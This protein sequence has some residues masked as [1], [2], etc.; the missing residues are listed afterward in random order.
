MRRLLLQVR[1]YRAV[2]SSPATCQARGAE[3]R[4]D[5]QEFSVQPHSSRCVVCVGPRRGRGLQGGLWLSSPR[6][7]STPAPARSACGR[8]AWS[9]GSLPCPCGCCFLPKGALA[10]GKRDRRVSPM[11]TAVSRA[12]RATLAAGPASFGGPPLLGLP[13]RHSGFLLTLPIWPSAPPP[14]PLWPLLGVKFH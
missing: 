13:W 2:E 5:S 11:P 3:D 9:H 7:T 1:L 8:T 6:C 4:P 10:G 12:A 14:E